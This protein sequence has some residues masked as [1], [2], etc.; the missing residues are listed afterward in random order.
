MTLSELHGKRVLI[1]GY[2]KEGKIVE[3]FLRQE[4]PDTETLIADQSL[5]ADYLDQQR[6]ADIAIKTPGIPKRLLTI[7][8]T[9]ATN[10][11]FDQLRTHHA[12]NIVIGITGSK[13]KSTTS[14][15]IAHILTNAGKRVHLVGNIGRPALEALL[16]PIGHDDVFVIE[17]SSYQLDDIEYSP[18]IAVFTS[19]FPDH[20]NYHESFSN[21]FKAKSNIVRYSTADD[22]FIYNP[23]FSELAELA[24]TT[25]AK[26]VPYVDSSLLSSFTTHL[27]GQHNLDNIRAAYTV[28]QELKIDEAVIQHAIETFEPLP[29]RLA[30][31]GTFHDITFVDDANATTPE[32]VICALQTLPDVDTLFVGGEDRG[33]DFN[34]LAHTIRSHGV[35]NLVFFPTSGERI[36]QELQKVG[37]TPTHTLHTRDMKEAV[38]FAFQHTTPGKTCLLSTGSPSYGVWKNFEEKGELFT[39]WVKE[40]GA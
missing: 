7:P 28:A 12:H 4:V 18:H 31:V 22:L 1:L 19:L 6:E 10:L 14:S 27:K 37:M 34:E 35:R 40:L 15:L 5:R 36:K 8:Y 21:Y 39:T 25:A 16:E 17:L 26:S 3:R 38:A 33:Y 23:R 11:F 24:T 32:A 9:T 29:H 13:G 20:L 30:T 2:G